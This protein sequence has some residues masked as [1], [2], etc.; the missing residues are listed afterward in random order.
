MQ[1]L[2]QRIL[3]VLM[4]MFGFSDHFLAYNADA[5]KVVGTLQFMRSPKQQCGFVMQVD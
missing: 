5:V 4:K 3:S 2:S 1:P